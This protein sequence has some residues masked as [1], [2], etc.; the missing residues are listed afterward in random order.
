MNLTKENIEKILSYLSY[1]EN[2]NNEFYTVDPKDMFYPYVYSSKVNEFEKALY[3]EN[4][5]INFD[6]PKWQPEAKKMLDDESLIKSADIDTL[7]KLLTVHVRKERFCAGHLVS[8][9][10]SGHILAILRR[11]REISL[12]ME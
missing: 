4:I 8:M 5:L 11:L 1:F 3:D 10:E 6:W 12:S 7:R 9:I 2:N